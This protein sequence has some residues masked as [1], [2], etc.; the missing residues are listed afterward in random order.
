MTDIVER[1]RKAALEPC[2]GCCYG[3]TMIAAA[4]EIERLTGRRAARPLEEIKAGHEFRES[5]IP[6]AD[7]W[8][9]GA[10]MWFGWSIMDA[11]LAGIDWARAKDDRHR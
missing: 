3:E 11:F 4:D 6:R 5:L 7:D 10:P 8:R 9:G 1:L 2:D